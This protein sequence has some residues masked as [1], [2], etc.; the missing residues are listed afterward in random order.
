MRA[1]ACLQHTCRL[2]WH[3]SLAP[4]GWLPKLQR[5][6]LG[7]WRETLTAACESQ[8]WGRGALLLQKGKMGLEPKEPGR[9]ARGTWHKATAWKPEGRGVATHWPLHCLALCALP[10]ALQ[11]TPPCTFHS[12]T[13]WSCQ[14]F[15]YAVSSALSLI[16]SPLL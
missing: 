4:L 2:T 7:G 13:S 14:A 11:A 6:A 9:V 12:S 10:A 15:V 3:T 8:A 16:F 5:V 1:G